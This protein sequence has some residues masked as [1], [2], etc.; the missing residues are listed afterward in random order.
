MHHDLPGIL[1]KIPQQTWQVKSVE[2][3]TNAQ[4]VDWKQLEEALKMKILT[5]LIVSCDG[6]GTPESYE[7]L[8]PPSQWSK[9]IT[10]LRRASALQRRYDPNLCLMTR[11]I[12]T[13]KEDQYRWNAICFHFGFTPEFRRWLYLPE[14]QTNM[15]GRKPTGG[16]GICSFQAKPKRLFVDWDGTVVPCCAH[17]RAG[18]LGSLKWQTYNEVM[19]GTLRNTFLTHM[20]EHRTQMPICGTCEFDEDF[21]PGTAIRLNARVGTGGMVKP[22]DRSAVKKL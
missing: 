8:R 15:T 1:S 3:S 21:T 19:H 2:L 13:R 10:F 7:R 9:L 17:P 11:T 5:R 18:V 22:L 20:R 12:A 14:S 16:K 4:T 6:D